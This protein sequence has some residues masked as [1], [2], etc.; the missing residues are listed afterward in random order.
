MKL[1]DLYRYVLNT[2]LSNLYIAEVGVDNLDEKDLVKLLDITNSCLIDLHT[3]FPLKIST[4][5]I[6]SIEWKSQYILDSKY[7][8]LHGTEDV[9]YIADSLVH[10]FKDDVIRILG[11][12]NEIGDPLP[13][14]DPE[15]WASVFTPSFNV[16]Q[17]THPGYCQVFEVTYQA[18]HEVLDKNSLEEELN[19]PKQILDLLAQMIAKEYF[20]GMSGQEITNKTQALEMKINE[21]IVRMETENLLNTSDVTTNTKLHKRGFP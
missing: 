14:N 10:P 21:T 8:I 1:K 7:S 18:S 6:Q 19:L 9:R 5:L 13:I 11:V 17:L 4:V 20:S 16:L 3:R 12:T 15:Q 2:H